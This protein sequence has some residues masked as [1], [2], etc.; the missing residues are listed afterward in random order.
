VLGCRRK[1]VI[2]ECCVTFPLPFTSLEQSHATQH[3]GKKREEAWVAQRRRR[4]QLN[5]WV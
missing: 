1:I 3:L 4:K 5:G 2:K